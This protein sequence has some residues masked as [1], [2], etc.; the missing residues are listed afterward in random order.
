MGHAQR[1]GAAASIATHWLAAEQPLRAL[2]FLHLAGE[3]AGAQ[4][5]FACRTSSDFDSGF[6]VGAGFGARLEV[7]DPVELRAELARVGAE[8][9]ALY[10]GGP[11][12]GAQNH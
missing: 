12:P 6:A 4:R 10:S 11:G 9:G 7:L 1:G 8:L 3:L 2:P 5:R